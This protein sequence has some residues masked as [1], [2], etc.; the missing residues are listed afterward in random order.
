[1]RK[2]Y[3]WGVLCIC[4]LLAGCTDKA[5]QPKKQ[6]PKVQVITGPAITINGEKKQMEF[7]NTE[8]WIDGKREYILNKPQGAFTFPIEN[9]I[10]DVADV[11]KDKEE[12]ILIS[13]CSGN[14]KFEVLRI[15]DIVEDGGRLIYNEVE[16]PSWLTDSGTM[17]T[18]YT[19]CLLENEYKG[20]LSCKNGFQKHFS[21]KGDNLKEAKKYLYKNNQCIYKETRVSYGGMV[22]DKDSETFVL[23]E[24]FCS[25]EMPT[26]TVT[27]LKSYFKVKNGK[28]VCVKQK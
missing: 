3:V 24:E 8:L 20:S 25:A 11:D 14:G 12:E 26:F 15:V 28:L 13:S 2:K 6:S 27:Q 23:M 22:Y 4:I 19:V 5:M 21:L 18:S 9:A 16:L 10:L 1:M 17:I 7:H